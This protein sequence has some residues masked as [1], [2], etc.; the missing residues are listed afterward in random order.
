MVVVAQLVERCSVAAEVTGAEPVYHPAFLPGT[1][2]LSGHRSRKNTFMIKLPFFKQ[3]TNYF[4]GPAVVRMILAFYGQDFT[5]EELVKILKPT[6]DIGTG[7]TD[8]T[9]LF[10]ARGLAVSE[11]QNGSVQDLI[12]FVNKNIPVIV[13]YVE[14][15]DDDGHYAVVVDIKDDFI[16]LNDP[17]HGPDFKIPVAEFYQRW[18]SEF[19]DVH[20]WLL[21]V[22]QK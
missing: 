15:K 12:D 21:A 10:I 6:V 11:K 7:Y 3:S 13:N 14:P 4:C 17:W 16:I 8:L 19:G 9:N 18:Q 20:R 5:E 1:I 22:F 2:F